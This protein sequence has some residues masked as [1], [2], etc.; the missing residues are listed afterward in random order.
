MAVEGEGAF[1]LRARQYRDKA[2]NA[3]YVTNN[4]AKV[5]KWC[6]TRGVMS[7]HMHLDCQS[8][9]R[10]RKINLSTD[11]KG[12]DNSKTIVGTLSVRKIQICW[13]HFFCDHFLIS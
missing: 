8:A 4:K 10:T 13:A 3:L 6:P 9:R 5:K 2:N 7:H 11:Q 12:C 1:P